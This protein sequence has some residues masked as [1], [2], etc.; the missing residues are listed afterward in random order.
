MTRGYLYQEAAAPA[1]V[2]TRR[3]GHG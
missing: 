2:I 3:F 1:E